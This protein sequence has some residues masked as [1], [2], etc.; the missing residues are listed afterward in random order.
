MKLQFQSLPLFPNFQLEIPD[1]ETPNSV[2][3]VCFVLGNASLIFSRY[4]P[5]LAQKSLSIHFFPPDH[6]PRCGRRQNLI[7]LD[8]DINRWNQVAYQFFHEL[9]HFTIPFDVHPKLCW[10][11]ESVCQAAST[12][13]LVQISRLFTQDDNPYAP[14]FTSYAI[15]EAQT[16]TPFDWKDPKELSLLESDPYLRGKNQYV[17]NHLLPIIWEAPRLWAAVPYLGSVHV[18]PSTQ[19]GLDQWLHLVPPDL[20]PDLQRIVDVLV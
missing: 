17:A 19:A 7:L 5:A 14:F 1:G 11:E 4:V 13:F 12:F 16:A 10:V 6:T 8:C 15:K 3:L 9:C 20:R 2:S 18:V